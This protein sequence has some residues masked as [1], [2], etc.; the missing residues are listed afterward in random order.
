MVWSKNKVNKRIML[1][2]WLQFASAH[3]SVIVL[4]HSLARSNLAYISVS[5]FLFPS[6]YEMHNAF[7][8]TSIKNGISTLFVKVEPGGKSYIC[9]YMDEILSSFRIAIVCLFEC[10]NF[11][12]CCSSLCWWHFL[13]WQTKVATNQTTKKLNETS[14]STITRDVPICAVNTKHTD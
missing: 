4:V 2:F 12:S 1:C 10:H 13:F 11:H 7:A 6:C 8:R 3:L 14:V 9:I 5:Y